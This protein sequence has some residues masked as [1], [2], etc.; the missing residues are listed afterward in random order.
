MQGLAE[1][2]RHKP[3]PVDRHRAVVLSACI[4]SANSD[5]GV[6]SLTVPTGGG[7]TLASLTFALR[8]AERHGLRRV[9]YAL[10]FTSIIEQTAAIFRNVFDDPVGH[11]VL[12]QHSTLD[13][14]SRDVRTEMAAE[15]WDA[16]IIVTTN[17]Q[18]FESL[19]SA[20]GSTCRKLHRIASSVIVLDEA[21][22]VPPQLLKP[23]LAVIDELVRNYRCTVV[24]CTATQP[25]ITKRDTFPIGLEPVHEIIPDPPALY[26]AMRRVEVQHLGKIEDEV[27]ARRLAD[28]EQVLCIVNTRRH[29]A[30]LCALLEALGVEALHLSAAMCPEHRSQRVALIREALKDKKPCR[31][32][33]TQ[34]I[35]AGVDVDFPTVYRALAGFDSVAQAAGRCNRE[36]WHN[37]GRV[38][39]F[40]SDH[41]PALSM[42]PQV[43]AA[44]ELM[45]DHPDPLA[46]EAINRYF[47]LVYWKRKHEGLKPW[48]VKDVMGCF[49]PQMNHRF[50]DADRDFK[51]I[52]QHTTPVVV[53][54]GQAGQAIVDHL[55]R[56]DEPDWQVLRRAQRYSVSVYEKQLMML[57]EN[58]LVTPCFPDIDG[59]VRFWALTNRRG[60]DD[61]FGLRMELEGW[62][63]K[64]LTI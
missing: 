1:P 35:E 34:V 6:Y 57:K 30:A 52:D 14:D 4:A 59:R 10:P 41:Q 19:F 13:P 37:N 61:Q 8:H 64:T 28:H 47:G 53:P 29:A 36:G 12:E 18:L 54:F 15:N 48:D 39:V 40:N 60:Y 42:R 26:N 21:H 23:V 56:D 32:V 20:H 38:Y 33:S 31:I 49:Q 24:L 27:L 5:P 50:R 11:I 2:R 46:L 22:A 44:N 25:A 63:G 9:I 43:A 17:V 55:L 3:A 16:P 7:K 62:D 51:W 58:T 45:P